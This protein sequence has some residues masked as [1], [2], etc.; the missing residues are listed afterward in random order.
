[1]KSNK[2]KPFLLIIIWLGGNTCGEAARIC[3]TVK[4]GWVLPAALLPSPTIVV[5]SM[6]ALFDCHSG[7]HKF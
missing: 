5:L 2:T 4:V 3:K 7:F 6:F 1:M